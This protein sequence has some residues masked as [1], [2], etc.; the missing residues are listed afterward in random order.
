VNDFEEDLDDQALQDA[1]ADGCCEERD[2][3]ECVCDG[4]CKP[5]FCDMNP[6]SWFHAAEV[7]DG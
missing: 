5:G 1:F 6:W 2:P 7:G 3:D 4:F